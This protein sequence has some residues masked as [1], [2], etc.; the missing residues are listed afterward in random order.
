MFLVVE[1]SIGILIQVI[2]PYFFLM[3]PFRTLLKIK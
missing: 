1:L 3:L 2:L